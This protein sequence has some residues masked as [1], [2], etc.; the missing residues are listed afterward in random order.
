MEEGGQGLGRVD[1]LFNAESMPL[2]TMA[3]KVLF[4][5]SLSLQVKVT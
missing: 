3:S 1:P 2:S 5:M 4:L